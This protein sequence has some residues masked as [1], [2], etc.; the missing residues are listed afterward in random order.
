[1][2]NGENRFTVLEGGLSSSPAGTGDYTFRSAWITDTRLMGVTCMYVHWRMNKKE[3]YGDLHQYFY[4]DAEEFGFD[5]FE[6][7]EGSDKDALEDMEASFIGGLGGS[8]ENITLPEAIFLLRRYIGFN[9]RKGIPLP[10]GKDRYMFMASTEV[11]LSDD[12]QRR[13]F[14]RC[15]TKIRS[16]SELANYFNMRYFAADMEGAAF[17]CTDDS[18]V[19]QVFP[20]S[21]CTL[22]K[23][24]LTFSDKDRLCRCESLVGNEDTYH[25]VVTELALSRKGV[26]GCRR[27][28]DMEISDAEAYMNLSHPEFVTVYNYSGT[29]EQ[30]TRHSTRLTRNAMIVKEHGGTTYMIFNPDN[31]HVDSEHYRL[32]DD[33]TGVYHVSDNMQL[34]AA[35][36]TMENIRKLEIDLTLSSAYAYLDTDSSYEFNE[37]VLMHYLES[38][39]TSFSEFIEAIKLD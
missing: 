38:D 20:L 33:M 29:P 32:Y 7:I 9:R 19:P 1:M 14:S 28:S 10:D 35:A 39:F 3:K 27:I 6:Y 26:S 8:R 18:V 23:N 4:F 36:S 25:L 13:L 24:D 37:P 2:T 12:A 30:F 22:Y 17:L 34:L 31:T 16:V 21:P 15:C 11:I 5:R